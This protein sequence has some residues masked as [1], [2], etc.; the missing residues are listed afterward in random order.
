MDYE[1]TLSNDDKYILVRVDRPMNNALGVECGRAATALGKAHG[2]NR[3]LFDLRGA[4]NIETVLPNYEFAYKGLE[5]FGFPKDSRSV[6]LTD[7]DDRSHDFMETVFVN[8]GYTVRIFSDES[9]A[10]AWLEK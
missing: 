10:I 3:F 6:L 5:S 8:A 4:P 7:A 9:A 1:V 2:V